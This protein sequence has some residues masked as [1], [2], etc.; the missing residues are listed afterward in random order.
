MADPRLSHAQGSIGSPTGT[1]SLITLRKGKL[2]KPS[3]TLLPLIRYGKVKSRHESPEDPLCHGQR[4]DA[5][6]SRP[7]RGEAY[8][9][10]SKSVCDM[11][12]AQW[13]A[14]GKRIGNTKPLFTRPH[15]PTPS[16]TSGGPAQPA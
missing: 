5:E 6:R 8:W 12:R 14:G 4:R 11:N 1:T 15:L 16:R 3:L 10:L 7:Q 9:Y 13:D 2:L